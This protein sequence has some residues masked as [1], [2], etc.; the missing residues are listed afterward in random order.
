MMNKIVITLIF[1]INFSCTNDA[2]FEISENT[3]F[4]DSSSSNSSVTAVSLSFEVSPSN[5]SS[6]QILNPNIEVKVLDVNNN[7]VTTNSAQITLSFGTDPSSGSASLGGTKTVN[8]VNGVATFSDITIDKAFSGYTLQASSSGLTSAISSSF[9]ITVG[10]VSGLE[11][12][13]QPTD[14]VVNYSINPDISVKAVDAGGNTVTSFTNSITIG[15]LN[16]PSAANLIGTTLVSAINGVATFSDL[17]IDTSGSA[18]TLQVSTA[19]VSSVVSNAFN[20][21]EAYGLSVGWLHTCVNLNS[22]V[23]C[24]GRNND[25]ELGNGTNTDTADMVTP[26]PTE[27]LDD[28]GSV[29]TDI[30]SVITN[31]WSGTLCSIVSSSEARCMGSA[32]SGQ[33]GDGSISINILPTYIQTS[34]SVKLNNI[35]KISQSSRQRT[36][37]ISNN[38]LY[39]MGDNQGPNSS[40]HQLISGNSC[41]GLSEV[42]CNSNS[43]I[44]SWNSFSSSCNRKTQVTYATLVTTNVLDVAAGDEHM[45]ILDTSNV[46]KCWGENSSGQLGDGSTT[47]ISTGVSAAINVDGLVGDTPI[48]IQAGC[49]NTCALLA[50]STVKCWGYGGYGQNGTN[51]YSDQLT[52]QLVLDA[53]G[54]AALSNISQMSIGCNHSCFLTTANKI[55]CVGD[56]LEGEIGGSSNSREKLVIEH[57]TLTNIIQVGVGQDHTCALDSSNKVYCWGGNYEGESGHNEG[58]SSATPV[59]VLGL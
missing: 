59:E 17:K 49:N 14:K 30:L 47:D 5:A 6:M 20:I 31:P 57:P 12:V 42:D 23:K 36:C 44:C 19:G 48:E 2:K 37:V 15:I 10:E 51:S 54:G 25:Y 58:Y 22:S 43:N 50:D 9:N 3:K 26:T 28:A 1:F 7:I 46:V 34:A 24:F 53:T 29:A 4:T 13:S 16:N 56:N 33:R 21:V 45:C 52:A 55:Y 27:V 8:A 41:V 40:R 32:A 35:L 39:C 18:F 38:D 11:F